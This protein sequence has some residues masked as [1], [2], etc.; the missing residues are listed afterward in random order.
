MQF[1]FSHGS[2]KPG[3]VYELDRFPAVTCGF[4]Q[5]RPNSRGYVRITSADPAVAPEVQPNY[6]D[7]DH[8]CEVVVRGLKMARQYLHSPQL[9]RWVQNEEVPGA[10]VDSDADILEYARKTGNT[11]YHLVGS[12]MMGPRANPLA[13]VDPSLKVHGL[14]GLR[15]IDASVM[16]AVTSSNTCAASIMIGEKGADMIL[17]DTE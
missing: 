2:Y 1:V 6:L 15:V 7:D 16:P 13:V 11:G 8:D 14:S 17:R 10:G 3:K 5:Q 9:A 12:C 4:T